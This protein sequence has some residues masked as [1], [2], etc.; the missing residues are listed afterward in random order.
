[1]AAL[2]YQY[3]RN[4]AT[5]GFV[6]L[7]ARLTASSPEAARLW[8]RHEVV[9]PPHEYLVRLRHP[10]YGIIG[11]HVLFVPVSP[12]LWMYVMVLPPGVQPPPC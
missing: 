12:R 3:T 11:A 2:R 4:L 5:P 9:F 1:M 7:I 10:G 8:A 6:R